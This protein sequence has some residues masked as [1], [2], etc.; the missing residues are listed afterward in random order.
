MRT[1]GPGFSSTASIYSK[2]MSGCIHICE[3]PLRGRFL[4]FLELLMYV[5]L[6]FLV[7]MLRNYMNIVAT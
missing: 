4:L 5:S 3:S 2:N 6:F 1:K 7:K